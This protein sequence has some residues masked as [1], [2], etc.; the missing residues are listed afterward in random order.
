MIKVRGRTFETNSSSTHSLVVFDL[1]NFNDWKN[2]K[3]LY[4][5]ENEKFVAF[6]EAIS[7]KKRVYSEKIIKETKS[8]TPTEQQELV[9]VLAGGNEE[10]IYKFCRNHFKFYT[11]DSIPMTFEEF[12][13]S[14]YNDDDEMDY[15]EKT[16]V[17][18]HGDTVVIW[19]KGGYDG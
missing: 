14:W 8:L 19:G 12:E 18:K 6:A 11:D 4:D 17:T 7:I 13:H 10:E 15:D 2:G 9:N 1:D 5:K 3:L 16:F